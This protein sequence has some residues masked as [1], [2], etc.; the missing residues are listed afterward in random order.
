LGFREW[1]VIIGSIIIAV[2]LA[3]I[4]T[5]IIDRNLP[6]SEKDY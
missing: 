4:I 1:M 2:I 3:K 6:L 5:Y